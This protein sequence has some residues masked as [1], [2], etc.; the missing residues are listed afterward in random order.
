MEI[1]TNADEARVV[2]LV[3]R[4]VAATIGPGH[5][6]M[7]MAE[8]RHQ[9]QFADTVDTYVARVVEEVQQY[10]HGHADRHDVAVVSEPSEPP[11][12]VSGRLVMCGWPTRRTVGCVVEAAEVSQAS[13][14]WGRAGTRMGKHK[15][16]RMLV[17]RI[18]L[19]GV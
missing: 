13:S 9:R 19:C 15:A 2:D 3:G 11:D 12:V 14:P 7:V 16:S 4:D 6:D 8:A 10:I 17:D 18:R 1:I 5:L